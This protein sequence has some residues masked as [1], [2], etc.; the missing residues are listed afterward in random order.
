MKILIVVDMQNDF[1]TGVLGN[2][3]TE[4]VIP[5]V[6]KKIQHYADMPDAAII[7]TRDTHFSDYMSTPEG[8]K[9]PVPH[10]IANTAGWQINPHVMDASIGAHLVDIQNKYTFGL[11]DWENLLITIPEAFE[12]VEW[13]NYEIE[14]IEVIGVCTSICVVSNALILKAAFPAVPIT[15]DS[16]C[17]AC[18]TPQSHAAALDVM[19]MCQIDVI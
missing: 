5:A 15:V 8:K 14:S 12:D 13:D 7:Y 19:R 18:V 1:L 6:I 17:C 9:L 4:A 10:C 16:Q 2:A 11:I 3:E